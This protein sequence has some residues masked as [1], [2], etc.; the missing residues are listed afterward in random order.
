M[1]II[2]FEKKGNVVR[3]YLGADDLKDWYGDDWDDAPYDCN[4][5]S[6]YEQ[7][8]S[9]HRDIAFPFDSLVIEPCEGVTNCEWCKDDMRERKV[10]C[11]IV[12]PK[13]KADD[14]WHGQEFAHWVGVDGIQRYYF[15][16]RMEEQHGQD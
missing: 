1:I 5:G 4:A 7:F 2:D 10:P 3:S 16:D 13:E 9:G 8:V 11:I 15:G 14:S 6:V 12:V